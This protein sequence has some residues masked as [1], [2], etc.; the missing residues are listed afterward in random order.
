MNYRLN[1]FGFALS[2]ALRSNNSL[3]VGLRDQ[4][5]ALEWVRGNIAWFGGDP[6]RVTIFGQSSG[7]TYSELCIM[8]FSV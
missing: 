2:E 8:C 7:G 3:N 5:L 6:N 1:I 4:R